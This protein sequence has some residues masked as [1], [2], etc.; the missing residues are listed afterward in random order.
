VLGTASSAE[1]KHSAGEGQRELAEWYGVYRGGTRREPV[2]NE[3]ALDSLASGELEP[4]HRP[5]ATGTVLYICPE[6]PAQ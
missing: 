3:K 4:A 5:A 6:H 1:K 2:L